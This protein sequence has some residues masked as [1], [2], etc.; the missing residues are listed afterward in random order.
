MLK[1]P[2]IMMIDSGLCAS[3]T[4]QSVESLADPTSV[5]RGPVVETF[6]VSRC[7]AFRV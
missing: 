3:I 1:Q 7:Q 2:K 4:N 5:M 6:V